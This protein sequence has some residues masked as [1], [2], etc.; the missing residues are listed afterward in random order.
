MSPRSK[1][2]RAHDAVFGRNI[3]ELRIRRGMSEGALGAAVGVNQQQIS[4][5]EK[6]TA[7]FPINRLPAL[8]SALG[9]GIPELFRG[10]VDSL[11]PHPEEPQ[12]RDLWASR[13]ATR[14]DRLPPRHRQTV[15]RLIDDLSA[16]EPAQQNE[17]L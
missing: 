1:P 14:L 15:S 16:L 5:Y 10:F 9:V 3:R 17:N 11:K 7:A 2:G 8:C 12:A 6:G 13:T 4:K